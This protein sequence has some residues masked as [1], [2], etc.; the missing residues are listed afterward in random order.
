M[1]KVQK[2]LLEE[3]FDVTREIQLKH[4]ELYKNLNETPL[5]LSEFGV[6][7]DI[8]PRDF[9]QY[10]ESLKRQLAAFDRTANLPSTN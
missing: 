8:S 10:L 6:A 4:P 2:E 3:I 5:F 7:G 9:K 1:K